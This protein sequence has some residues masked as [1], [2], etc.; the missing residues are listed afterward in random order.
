M[1]ESGCTMAMAPA[2]A[3]APTSSGLLQ[4]YMAPQ[5]RGT[6]APVRAQKASVGEALLLMISRGRC[7]RWR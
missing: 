1:S 7:A 3:T 5:M 2:A 4:G 6:S